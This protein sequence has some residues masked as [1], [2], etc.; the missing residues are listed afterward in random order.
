[1]EEIKLHQFAE[2]LEL[3]GYSK[4][5]IAGYPDMVEKYMEY[6][7]EKEN[8]KS[9]DAAGPLELK[10]YQ[11]H[12]QFGKLN[13]GR[14][15]T[16]KSVSYH[17]CGIMAFYRI[18]HQEGLIK[19]D[20][21][22]EIRLP[23]VRKNVPRY[24]PSI[25]EV[26]RILDAAKPVNALSIRDRAM[27]E[28]M[29]ATGVRSEELRTIKIDDYDMNENTVFITGKGSRDRIVPVGAWVMPYVN[30][31]LEKSRPLLEREP[32]VLMFISKTGRRLNRNALWYIVNRYAEKAGIKKVMPHG[33]RHACATHLLHNGADIRIVQELL[34]HRSLASTQIYTKVDIHFLQQ[35]HTKYHPRERW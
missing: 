21:S 35:E 12:L 5:T 17:L 1:M 33:F 27:L 14:Q 15:L 22:K 8:I 11:T 10:A 29:Y 32:T 2:K 16:G 23:V 31:Y 4:R 19:A 24:V 3:L 6:L 28:F 25:G 20:L 7:D 9:I 13:K 18:M 26:Q 30:E 34:G